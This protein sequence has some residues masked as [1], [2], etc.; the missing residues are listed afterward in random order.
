MLVTLVVLSCAKWVTLV[1]DQQSAIHRLIDLSL[2][3]L[4]LGFLRKIVVDM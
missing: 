3:S 4:S 1:I 2:A